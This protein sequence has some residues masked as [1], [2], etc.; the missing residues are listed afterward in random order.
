M[1]YISTLTLSLVDANNNGKSLLCLQGALN[2][3]DLKVNY[4]GS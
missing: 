4:W 2:L 3:I 1:I